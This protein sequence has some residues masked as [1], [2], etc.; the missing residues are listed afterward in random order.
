MSH[1]QELALQDLCVALHYMLPS[2][3]HKQTLHAGMK[4]IFWGMQDKT[5]VE[6]AKKYNKLPSQVLLRWGIQNGT[7]LIPKS[8]NAE[9]QK[10]RSLPCLPAFNACGTGLLQAMLQGLC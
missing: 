2:L 10:V 9:H 4:W 6:L 7:S 1:C 5:V 3:V 8:T